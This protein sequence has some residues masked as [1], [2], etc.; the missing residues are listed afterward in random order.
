VHAARCIAH[1]L[2]RW[3]D[4]GSQAE[5]EKYGRNWLAEALPSGA[6][7]STKA[8]IAEDGDVVIFVSC[9]AA[10]ALL[11]I[12]PLTVPNSL[13]RPQ[14]EPPSHDAARLIDQR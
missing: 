9:N 10:R 14:Q 11:I 1:L 13:A 7:C 6:E 12:A 3:S 8:L 5:F 2:R 4:N